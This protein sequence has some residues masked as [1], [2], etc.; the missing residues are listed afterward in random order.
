VFHLPQKKKV[1]TL[2]AVDLALEAH[3]KELGLVPT[4]SMQA[5]LRRRH[6]ATTTS[7]H[8]PHS[9]QGSSASSSTTGGEPS[10]PNPT[11]TTTSTT[12]TVPL[13]GKS[14]EV[15]STFQRDN[16]SASLTAAAE[17][18]AGAVMMSGAASAAASAAAADSNEPSGEAVGAA[19]KVPAQWAVKAM[20]NTVEWA[21]GAMAASRSSNS[22]SSGTSGGSSSSDS[23]SSAWL[24]H[25]VR[26]CGVAGVLWKCHAWRKRAVIFK[27]RKQRLC[28]SNDA[29]TAL[30]KLWTLVMFIVDAEKVSANVGAF[31]CTYRCMFRLFL[32]Y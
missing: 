18:V 29:L 17:M 25:T 12:T 32:V 22:A 16:R 13:A 31:A 9:N 19:L 21:A 30:L 2:R 15:Y 26:A 7:T 1:S 6:S 8:E 14:L 5:R 24:G 23:D 27:R 4:S 3:A 11:T 28:G 10:L 20:A